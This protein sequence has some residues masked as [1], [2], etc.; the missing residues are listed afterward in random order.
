MKVVIYENNG[1][2]MILD[3]ETELELDNCLNLIERVW[4]KEKKNT[5]ITWTEIDDVVCDIEDLRHNPE[6]ASEVAVMVKELFKR[7]GKGGIWN[8]Q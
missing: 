7:A 5:G 4:K 2:R 1:R 8:D 3:I 6:K